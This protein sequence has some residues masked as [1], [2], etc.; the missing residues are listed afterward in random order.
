MRLVISGGTPILATNAANLL[1]TLLIGSPLEFEFAPQVLCCFVDTEWA[2][3]AR[4]LL[5]LAAEGCLRSCW[6]FCAH[7]LEKGTTYAL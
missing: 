4:C 6:R 2:G 5:L 3:T 1:W 7:L